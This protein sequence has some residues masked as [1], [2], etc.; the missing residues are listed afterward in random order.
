MKPDF[1]VVVVNK[2]SIADVSKEWMSYGFTVLCETPAALDTDTLSELWEM[3][4]AGGRLMVAEQYMYD[5]VYQTQLKLLGRGLIGDPSFLHLSLAHEYHGASL[6]RAYLSVDASTAFTVSAK[7]YAFPTAE[8][9]SRYE[10]FT[11]G[12]VAEKKRTI[13][14]FEFAD[15]KVAVYEFDSEQYRSPIRNN[16]VKLQGVRGEMK[17]DSFFWLNER[18][19]PRKARLVASEVQFTRDSDNPNLQVGSECETIRLVQDGVADEVVY[20][21]PFG[22]CG[23]SKGETAVVALMVQAAAYDQEV[24]AQNLRDALQD[25]Y[26]ALLMKQAVETKEVV[27]SQAQT[28]HE[29][30]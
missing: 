24:A 8:T 15:G 3:H 29:I 12:R 22:L 17:D 2:T 28:W 13:A 6:M 11:D 27:C 10:R 7:T 21:A 5:P 14:T 4:R 1:V 23:M 9:L 20:E 18:N 26:M 25:A 30:G 19:A 16:Y